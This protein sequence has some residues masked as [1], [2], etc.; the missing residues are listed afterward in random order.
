MDIPL[1]RRIYNLVGVACCALVAVA[2]TIH[3][4]ISEGSTTE[5]VVSGGLALGLIVLLSFASPAL[6]RRER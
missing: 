3:A 1:R 4:L 5:R 6:L 2:L